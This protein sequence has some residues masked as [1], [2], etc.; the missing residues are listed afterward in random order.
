MTQAP[1]LN[2]IAVALADGRPI[3]WA[4]ID[5]RPL[6]ESERGMV[7]RFRLIERVL[8]A[9][10]GP[11]GELS[12]DLPSALATADRIAA[13][14]GSD[15]AVGAT[16]GPLTILERIGRGTYGDV[17]RAHDPRLDRVV[18]LKLLRR[19]ESG[20][21]ARESAVIEEGR[22]LA[23]VQHPNVVTV[24][25][26]ERIDGRVGLWMEFLE[27][28]TL[29]EEVR[30]GGPR[31]ARAIARIGRDLCSALTA[32]HQAGLLHHDVKAQNVMRTQDGRIVLTDFGAGHDSRG[33]GHGAAPQPLTGTPAYLAPEVLAGQPATA[34]SE[35]YS[36][37]VLLYHLA[38]GTFP[39]RGR[40]LQEF[41]DAHAS[42][43]N[44]ELLAARADMPPA[45][46]AAITRCLAPAPA[47]RFQNM[48]DLADALAAG[49]EVPAAHGVAAA[50][51]LAPRRARFTW[52]A[53][54]IVL[55]SVGLAGAAG[56]AASYTQP[57][58]FESR[59][60][61]YVTPQQVSPVYV[62]AE[63]TLRIADRVNSHPQQDNEP[64][65]IG[66]VDHGAQAVRA[67]DER[68]A[69]GGPG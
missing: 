3:D 52:R 67:R 29:A 56:W 26:A 43:A 45:L 18:A 25:G 48:D 42:G 10:I 39:V 57:E 22:L 2:D 17:Y 27:G 38:T 60:L 24:H 58:I 47:D 59:A 36:V 50:A 65:E 41:R 8:Q 49:V 21:D 19:R 51:I 40:S 35:V 12:V 6:T 1:W 32:V 13:V 31:S 20:G 4:S 61:I 23:R 11:D 15:E 62:G 55:A 30:L 69:D 33:N 34:Q 68:A 46:V 54:G 53:A 44:V 5:A 37:G 28:H 14:A 63:G 66:D 9:H 64:N 16:W 7:A